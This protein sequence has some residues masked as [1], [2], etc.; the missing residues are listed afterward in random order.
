MYQSSIFGQQPEDA[1]I[2]FDMSEFAEKVAK[3]VVKLT[4]AQSSS[5]K[6][7]KEIPQVTSNAANLTEFV[8]QYP[9][10]EILGESPCKILRRRAC[11]L[12][13]NSA[14]SAATKPSGSANGCL[15]LG[16]QLSDEKMVKLVSGNCDLWWHQKAKLLEHLSGDTHQKAM[17]HAKSL[18]NILKREVKVV[19]NQLRTALGIGKS[20][21]A[22]VHYGER[23]AEL[24]L[25]GGDVGDYSHSRKLFPDMLS[26][27]TS[28]IDQKTAEFLATPLP[29]TGL[30]PNFYVTADKSTN[31]RRQNQVSLLCPVVD[32]KRQGLPLDMHQ[33]Y[34]TTDGVGGGNDILAEV[35]LKDLETFANIK[36][37]S[38][39]QMQGKVVDGQYVNNKF[40]DAMNKPIFDMLQDVP[41]PEALEH[42]LTDAF[43]WLCQW[44]PAH[45]LD[46]VFSKMK[47]DAFVTRLL[48]RTALYHQIFGRGRCTA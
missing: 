5:D 1:N 41:S 14:S 10:F 7:S 47:N 42:G 32:G 22:A 28:Y 29:N 8:E 46:K 31:L 44:D 13:L 11:F 45:W 30:K 34:K 48:R 37:A 23:I 33:V 36:E 38:L 3:K 26:V 35:I 19:K 21:T 12:F 25:A 43:W 40:I 24:F 20:K 18:E 17:L 2:P 9:D 39:L 15:S 27:M 4:S 16:L 6:Q